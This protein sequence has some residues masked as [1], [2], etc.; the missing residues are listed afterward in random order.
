MDTS[1]F[2]SSWT[3][4]EPNLQPISLQT[5]NRFELTRETVAFLSATGLPRDAAPFLSFVG[6]YNPNDRYSSISLLT[7]WFDFLEPA[8]NQF[9]VI[10]SDGNGNIIAINTAKDC[11]VEWLDHEDY[12][13][14]RF[15]NSSVT[16]LA[17]C[18]L[19]YRSFL[20]VTNGNKSADELFNTHFTDE[21]FDTLKD[22][23]ENIDRRTVNDGF[24]QE[25]LNLLLVNRQDSGKQD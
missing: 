3:I 1:K 24:W 5:L 11:I 20:K 9:V 12:F 17:N 15:M 16:Q 6:D 18:L 4:D 25:E 2:Q 13:S 14:A 10:G 23:L 8:Y 22:I 21:Q 19:C 7:D